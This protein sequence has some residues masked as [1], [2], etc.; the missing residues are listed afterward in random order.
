[1]AVCVGEGS[2]SE[3]LSVIRDSSGLT[4]TH[5]GSTKKEG[6]TEGRCGSS[7]PGEVQIAFE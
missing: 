6:G 1:M 5:M 2:T 7:H 4:Q 3:S